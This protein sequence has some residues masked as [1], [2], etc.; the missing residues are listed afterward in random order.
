MLITVS[1]GTDCLRWKL[2][3]AEIIALA[4]AM[5]IDCM[6][7]SFSQGLILNSNRLKNS[8]ALALTMGL[9]QGI[10]PIFGYWGT[11]VFI[12]FIKPFSH[13]LVFLIFLMLGV[14]FIYEAFQLKDE[15]ICCINLKNLLLMGIATSIDAL[16]SGITLKLTHTSIILSAFIIG[17]ISFVM[18]LCGFW[19]ELFFK[20]LPS[21]LLE[22]SGGIILIFM[23]IRAIF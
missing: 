17:L 23:A 16:A 21:K 6:V 5:G 13:F 9:C 1:L 14:K 8:F 15:N 19:S 3:L 22:V 4:I 18:S 7:V 10:M 11:H 2:S 20:N 12:G